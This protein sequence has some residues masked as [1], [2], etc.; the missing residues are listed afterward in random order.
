MRRC[1]RSKRSRRR[2]EKACMR[3]RIK[4]SR[5]DGS[6]PCLRC[7]NDNVP[8]IIGEKKTDFT[9][10][11]KGTTEILLR[12]Q[13]LLVAGLQAMHQ[14]LVGA[15]AWPGEPLEE[16]HGQPLVHDMLVTLGIM[17]PKAER[18]NTDCLFEDSSDELKSTTDQISKDE[19]SGNRA[20]S[21]GNEEVLG[22]TRQT[23]EVCFDV[24]ELQPLASLAIHTALQVT[25]PLPPHTLS[26][27]DTSRTGAAQSSNT[28]GILTS[29]L[30]SSGP[31]ISDETLALSFDPMDDYSNLD[32]IL[33][34]EYDLEADP[35]LQV[36]MS[37]L[38]DLLSKFPANT[39][40]LV[41]TTEEPYL[42][43]WSSMDWTDGIVPDNEPI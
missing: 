16:H 35:G 13:A 21:T 9:K 19:A 4:K 15:Q 2:V 17:K 31:K 23:N 10:A 34:L 7:K 37:W 25:F 27:D 12:Q 40:D 24:Q 3:C 18:I 29:S 6:L 41:A 38:E 39:E 42:S 11:P 1:Q 20:F 33:P 22:E 28:F 32:E 8:C 36:D 14:I 43:A 30:L 5:C 26:P